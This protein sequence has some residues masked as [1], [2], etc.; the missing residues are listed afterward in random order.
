MGEVLLDED[1][2]ISISKEDWIEGVKSS[3]EDS[4]STKRVNFGDFDYDPVTKGPSAWAQQKRSAG[5]DPTEHRGFL[6][7]DGDDVDDRVQR[8]RGETVDRSVADQV[9]TTNWI[10]G[11]LGKDPVKASDLGLQQQDQSTDSEPTPDHQAKP[12][13]EEGVPMEHPSPPDQSSQDPRT[14][15]PSHRLDASGNNPGRGEVGGYTPPS[16][17]AMS[18]VRDAATG[19]SSDS[20]G[21]GLGSVVSNPVVLGGAGLGLAALLFFVL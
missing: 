11:Q 7:A 16:R 10:R 13:P 9:E 19:G 2:D 15:T 12:D 17:P 20:S 18:A 8:A 3:R 21:G 1:T 6:D 4:D 14:S 5:L